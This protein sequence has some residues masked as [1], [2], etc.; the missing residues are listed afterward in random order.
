MVQRAFCTP[1][2]RLPLLVAAVVVVLQHGRA[3]TALFPTFAVDSNTPDATAAPDVTIVDDV[4]AD[5]GDGVFAT[6]VDRSSTT[7]DSTTTGNV[8][9]ALPSAIVAASNRTDRVL[10][11]FPVPVDDE[12]LSDDGRRS[13]V[14]L[15][16]YECRIQG[17]ASH[18]PCALG[19]GVCCV[20]TATCGQEIFNN[21]TYFVN[22]HFPGLSSSSSTCT[23]TIKKVVPNVSQLRLDF[24]HFSMGQPNRRTGVCDSDVFLM[25]AGPARQLTL[26]GQNSGQH[27]YF[28][29]DSV[30]DPISITM[31]LSRSDLS[32]I[33]EIKVS[34]IVFNQ[35]APAGCL[36]YHQGETGIIRTM[37]FADNGRH[38]A[39]QDYLICVR[40]ESGMCSIAYEPCD[41][42][43]FRIGPPENQAD[44]GSGGGDARECDDR[45]VM[46]CDSEDFI[47]P[48]QNGGGM[49]GVCD[50]LH[51]GSSF[52]SP[53]EVPCRVESSTTPFNIRVQFGP[54]KE[55][56]SPDDNI[57]MCLR[58]E[59]L[60]CTS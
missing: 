9:A 49:G 2:P 56:E 42:N 47:M 28:D 19:F 14:C 54:G 30:R 12:C 4:F 58:Y 41:E 51:C 32:R 46:P 7:P 15:N 13:G 53:G 55:N 25:S 43:S 33:W 36:Q 57:G 60:P 27:M 10:N 24:V 29:V 22:P 17:G 37:N 40:Q 39:N 18:G 21:V 3:A 44:E 26:C 50:L 38:L 16:T 59:Q 52:C 20:F 45:I 5:P 48:K 6:A 31:N 34:Q 8:E 23:I 11:F 35:R 1:P